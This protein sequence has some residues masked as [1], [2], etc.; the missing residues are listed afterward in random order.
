MG[1]VAHRFVAMLAI[2]A[3]WASTGSVAAQQRQQTIVGLSFEAAPNEDLEKLEVLSGLAVGEPYRPLSVRKAVRRLYQVGRF[4]NVYVRATTVDSGVRLRIILPPRPRI[5]NFNVESEVLDDSDVST[6]LGVDVGD[7]FDARSI[8]AWRVA[9]QGVL[10]NRGYRDATVHI[11]Y[12][13]ANREGGVDVDVKIVDGP[14][15]RLAKVILT[16]RTRRPLWL[17]DEQIDIDSGDVLDMSAIDESIE[18]LKAFYRRQGYLDAR[19]E[20]RK[21]RPAEPDPRGPRA[22]VV[23]HIASGPKVSVRFRGNSAVGLRTLQD[24]AELLQELGTGP[25]ALAEVRERIVARYEQRGYWRVRVAPAVRETA[26]GEKKEVLFSIRED[27][28]SFVRQVRFPGNKLFERKQLVDTVVAAVNDS[29]AS[30]AGQPGADPAVVDLIVGDVSSKDTT[31]SPGNEAPDPRK[32][33]IPSAYR[34]AQDEL[35]DLYRAE[36]YQT[37]QVRE[38]RVEAIEGTDLVDVVIP[39]R[40]G[41]QWRIGVVSFSGNRAVTPIE[42]LNLVGLDPGRKEGQPLAFGAVEQARRAILKSYRDRGFLYAQL[43]DEL[44]PM[45]SRGAPPW[46]RSSTAAAANIRQLCAR[47]EAG[48]KKACEVE[49]VFRIVEGPRVVTQDIII[50]G[51]DR[52]LEGIV[53]NEL[54]VSEYT[55]LRAKD[56]EQTRDNLLRLGVFDIVEVRPFEEDVAQSEKDVLVELKERDP[57]WLELGIGAS[58]EDGLRGSIAFG[59][60]NLFGSALRLQLQGRLNVWLPPLLVLYNESLRNQIE[61]F[62]TGFGT[63]GRLEYEVAAGF[64]YP[65]IPFLPRGFSAGLDMIV[66]RDFDPAFL[67][68]TQTITLVATYKAATRR[69]G[70]RSRIPSFQLRGNLERTDL[71]CNSIF[72]AVTAGTPDIEGILNDLALQCSTN[73]PQ[74]NGETDLT[75]TFGGINFYATAG[76][77]IIWDLRDDSLDPKSGAYF[78]TSAFYAFGLDPD[79][80]DYVNVD[81]QANFYLPLFP[82]LVFAVAGLGSSLIQVGPSNLEIPLNRRLFAGGRTTIRGYAEKTLLPQDTELDDN[83]GLPLARI[84]TGGQT[85]AALKSELRFLIFQSLAI[86]MFYDVGDLWVSG[87]RLETQRTIAGGRRIVRGLAMGAGLGLRVATPIGPLAIDL[88]VPVNR[89]D[90]GPTGVQLHF[91]VGSF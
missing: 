26:D 62:Y 90:P 37:V 82:R 1:V 19:V 85:R 35:A 66:L 36:G 42:L 73:L 41:I 46:V 47:A 68:N 3:V 53:R 71:E 12:R 25:S 4:E 88:A 54:A 78:E 7:D 89:R 15:T 31:R 50:K 70:R 84:S 20:L 91:A 22:E 56:M 65:R 23:L 40:Q 28:P 17:L 18:E 52:T 32:V 9:V 49:L 29:L 2:G 74:T 57:Y 64:S 48:G 86:S 5:R 30:A 69:D 38:P 77:R 21:I 79:S 76:P 59:D 44:R 11:A 6:A 10:A 55:I 61:S 14:V 75:E 39:V 87:F 81:V 45:L 33:Y 51:L 24:D 80:P 72:Q 60:G 67:E 34:A 58:T 13:T 16:G 63:L 83:T 8:G 27:R 43:T